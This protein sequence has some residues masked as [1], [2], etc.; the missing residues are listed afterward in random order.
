MCLPTAP[1][2]LLRH[3]GVQPTRTGKNA[4]KGRHRHKRPAQ[5]KSEPAFPSHRFT[6]PHPPSHEASAWQAQ[7]QIVSARFFS[8][9]RSAF[10][11][12]DEPANAAALQRDI[13]YYGWILS[14]HKNNQVA[15]ALMATETA[16]SEI[17][18]TVIVGRPFP[19]S[20]RNIHGRRIIA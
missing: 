6:Y 19:V 8:S 16:K 7:A 9:N 1:R 17:S 20:K 2:G 11:C 4:G 5:N 3:F 10:P 13:R 12:R 18:V 15:V 14:V